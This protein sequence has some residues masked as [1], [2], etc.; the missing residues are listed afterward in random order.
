LDRLASIGLLVGV[1]LGFGAS[2]CSSNT[3]NCKLGGACMAS[4]VCVSGVDGCANNCQCLRGTWQ[5]PCPTDVPQNASACSIEGAT[6]GYITQSAACAGSVDCSCQMA[7]WSCGPTCVI[8]DAASQETSDI[9]A[10]NGGLI[11]RLGG[12]CTPAQPCP[13]GVEGCVSNCQCL[14]GTWQ[15][16]CP[17][18]APQNAA[19]CSIEGATCGYITQSAACAGSVDCSCQMATWS[20]GPTCVVVEASIP[21]Q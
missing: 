3:L 12:M 5:T 16:P 14:E 13:G 6:C 21:E 11:C 2:D 9:S 20:C 10:N 18:D 8:T 7:A 4:Q 15:A 1:A 17:T 19:A